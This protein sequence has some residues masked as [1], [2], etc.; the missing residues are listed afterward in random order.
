MNQIDYIN[1][2]KPAYVVVYSRDS[3]VVHVF[4][5]KAALEN[6][7]GVNVMNWPNGDGK[8]KTVWYFDEYHG[9]KTKAEIA[10][11]LGRDVGS[12]MKGFM[13]GMRLVE[14]KNGND[15]L[16]LSSG[17]NV[18]NLHASVT[19]MGWERNAASLALSKKKQLA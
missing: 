11:V 7:S 19:N 8:C 17:D 9:A 15:V 16:I 5:L 3:E 12:L 4:N 1:K 10:N 18:P 2:N 14:D 13:Q 6:R